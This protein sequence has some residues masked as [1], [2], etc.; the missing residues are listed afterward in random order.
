MIAKKRLTAA[1]ALS[2]ALAAGSH[3]VARADDSDKTFKIWWYETPDS[4]MGIAWNKAIE[5]FKA[6]HPD[7]TIAFEQKSWDQIEKAGSLILNSG[8]APDLLEYNKGNAIAG[9]AASQGLLTDLTDVAAERGWDKTLT[10]SEL[11]LSRYDDRGIFGTGPIWGIP[12]YGEFVAVYYNKNMFKDL[13]LEVPKTLAEFEKVMDAFVAKGITPIATAANDYPAQHLLTELALSKATPEWVQSYQGLKAPLDP[14]PYLYGAQTLQ[15]W[16]KKGY[17]SKDAT[18]LKA[19]DMETLF[20]TGKAPMVVSGTWF[21]GGFKSKIK[22]FEWG[23]FLFPGNTIS[24]G[25]TGNIW[26]VPKSAKHKDW[27]YEFIDIT[28]SKDN[29]ALL[30]NSGGVPV[31][32]DPASLTDPVGLMMTENFKVL[33]DRNGLGFYPDWPAPGFYEVMLQKTQALIGGTITPEE[34]VEQISGPYNEAQAE[35]N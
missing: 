31:A 7:V 17:V 4:A 12:D 23:Q 34:F 2:L 10:S 19:T 26:V 29:Q 33:A 21:G 35:A 24:S 9:L 5:E 3:G 1:L 14:A 25:S 27:A 30:G 18:G 15:D 6:K 13:G 20:E 32:A 11:L 16:V 28:L 22:D 8:E